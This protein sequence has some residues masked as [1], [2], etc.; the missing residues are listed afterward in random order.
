MF[1]CVD[2]D[3][4]HIPIPLEVEQHTTVLHPPG[5]YD[6]VPMLASGKKKKGC[7]Q[8]PV[9][10]KNTEKVTRKGESGLVAILEE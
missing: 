4:S 9:G 5:Y 2:L 7:L 8:G 1:P 3:F 6:H 10:T